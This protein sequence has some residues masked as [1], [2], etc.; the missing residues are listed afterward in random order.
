MIRATSP[1][2]ESGIPLHEKIHVIVQPSLS[3]KEMPGR[4]PGT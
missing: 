3:S 4:K 2:C 1:V